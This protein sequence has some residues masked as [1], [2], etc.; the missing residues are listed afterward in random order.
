MNHHEMMSGSR[1]SCLPGD[2]QQTADYV[3][4][5]LNIGQVFAAVLPDEKADKVKEVQCQA[6][7]NELL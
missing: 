7:E 3:A 4:R 6:R 5:E 1:D 2:N